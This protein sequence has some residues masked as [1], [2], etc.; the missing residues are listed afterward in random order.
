MKNSLISFI[1][2][3]QDE[4]LSI[5]KFLYE[6]PER[7]FEEYI[8]FNYITK[9]LRKYNF[10]VDNNFLDTPTAFC[11]HYG[12][13]Y[14]KIALLCKYSSSNS[15]QHIYGNNSNAAIA[16]GT[17]IALTNVVSKLNGE[18][19]LLGCPGFEDASLE[20][21]L[22]NNSILEDIDFLF[23]PQVYNDTILDYTSLASMSLRIISKSINHTIDAWNSIL[24]K[25]DVLCDTY[26]SNLS[27]STI[28]NLCVEFQI[29][30]INIALL[31]KIKDSL[32]KLLNKD[33]DI[34]IL[35]TPLHELTSNKT[36]CRLLAHNLKEC[37]IIHISN[38]VYVN[39]LI[40]SGNISKTIPAIAPFISISEDN[41][42][43]FPSANFSK[44]TQTNFSNKSIINSIL[45]L[46]ITSLD[47]IQKENLL[48]E[49][50][51]DF[52][53]K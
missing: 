50:K 33:Y 8:A 51:K 20:Y 11:A 46:S 4:I 37:G 38:N 5:N 18:I 32:I 34:F 41:S 14:P 27:I 44:I 26:S 10:T 45:A 17:A 21:R 30:S 49:I 35:D 19:V 29:K 9:I 13:T 48:M 42:V 12:T 24:N 40:C 2:T 31:S 6:N 7:P 36:L 52:Y 22:S 3:I 15:L 47:I 16:I 53:N 28:N 23:V 39:Q 1:S 25:L 43:K